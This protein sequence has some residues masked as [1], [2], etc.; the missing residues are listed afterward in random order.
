MMVTY[1][2]WLF[3]HMILWGEIRLNQAYYLI[4]V[5][6]K[7]TSEWRTYTCMVATIC[8]TCMHMHILESIG[9]TIWSKIPPKR[10]LC[11]GRHNS[12]HNN[13]QYNLTAVLCIDGELSPCLR[14]PEKCVSCHAVIVRSES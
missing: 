7:T 12:I 6:V 9:G 3:I 10:S 14:R 11:V 8:N 2:L 13:D 1:M 5:S 4:I